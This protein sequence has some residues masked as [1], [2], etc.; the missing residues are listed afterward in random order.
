MN[1]HLISASLL[2]ATL[3]V[4]AQA[5]P[6]GPTEHGPMPGPGAFGMR[7]P[8]T[9]APYSATFTS[10]LT[11]KLQDGTVLNHTS[12]RTVARD[13]LG[14]TREEITMPARGADGQAHT[15]IMI[16]DPVAHTMTRLETDQKIAIV[17]Q[18]PQPGQHGRRGPASP[19]PSGADQ[20]NATTDAPHH[21]P[22]E[23]KNVIVADLGSKTISGVIA[24]GKRVSRTVPANTMGNT[25]PIVSTHEEWFSP[26]LKI[27]LS[28]SDVDPFRGTHTVAVSAL[29]KAEPDA[30][31]FQ[32]PQGYTV[33][34]APERAGGFGRRGPRHDGPDA[35]PP[36]D[37][38]V[39]PSGM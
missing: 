24:T 8:V 4:F 33:Q 25:A 21:G 26:D 29:T 34:Q 14:R 1:K 16:L 6:A 2:L 19:P 35:P 37:A 9:N 17:R 15:A 7:Q 36:A 32:V 30:A 31:L 39:P 20:A 12:T 5:P 3:P 13:S 11:E 22:R 38:P 10:T 27:E 18:I 23:D 28:R